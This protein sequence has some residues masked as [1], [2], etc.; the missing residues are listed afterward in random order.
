MVAEQ[1]QTHLIDVTEQH[2]TPEI[3]ISSLVVRGIKRRKLSQRHLAKLVGMDHSGISRIVNNATREPS[4]ETAIEL[5]NVLKFK[6]REVIGTLLVSVPT[7]DTSFFVSTYVNRLKN[8]PEY[9]APDK[10]VP[11]A[12]SELGNDKIKEYLKM[13]RR[14]ARGAAICSNGL[15]DHSS[16]TRIISGE[17]VPTAKTIMSLSIGLRLEPEQILDLYYSFG[18]KKS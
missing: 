14:S 17:R 1:R 3:G 10:S 18:K 4:L 12:I 11:L 2:F 16:I 9:W 6:P 5:G 13:N 7:E 15:I 8:L